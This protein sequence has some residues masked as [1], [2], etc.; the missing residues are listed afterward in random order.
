MHEVLESHFNEADLV[1]LAAAV[2][3]VRPLAPRDV[4]IGKK[5]SLQSH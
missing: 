1:F 3:D 5:N 4:K 2:A